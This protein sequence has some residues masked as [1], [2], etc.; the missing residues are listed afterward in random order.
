MKNAKKIAFGAVF[1]ALGVLLLLA[2]SL[3]ESLDASLAVAASLITTMALIEF[4]T[5]LSL[6]VWAVVS[7]LSLILSPYNSACWMFFVFLGWYPIFK[8]R[9]EQIH[10]MLSWAVKVS[11]FNVCAVAYWFIFSKLLG[12]PFEGTEGL[13]LLIWLGGNVV[14]VIYDLVLTRMITLYIFAWRTRLGFKN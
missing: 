12:L 3:I 14:F 5:G 1:S 9:I 13:L 4:K 11:T 10:Y 2:G 6:S 8:R 7:A